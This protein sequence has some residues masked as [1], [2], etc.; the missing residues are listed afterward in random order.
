MFS[1]LSTRSGFVSG[2]LGSEKSEANIGCLVSIKLETV[3]VAALIFW[4]V[5]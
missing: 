1:I 3:V 5:Y 2:D 4:V